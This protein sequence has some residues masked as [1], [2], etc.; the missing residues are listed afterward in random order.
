MNQK[1]Y[2]LLTK[3]KGKQKTKKKNLYELNQVL[4]LPILFFRL[5][6]TN[7]VLPFPSENHECKKSRQRHLPRNPRPCVPQSFISRVF[8]IGRSGFFSTL[9][10]PPAL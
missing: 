8:Y 6:C 7:G 9:G 4:P 1:V 5:K 10:Q 3:K 2:E